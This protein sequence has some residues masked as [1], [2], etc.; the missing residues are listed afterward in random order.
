MRSVP[1]H[2][3]KAAGRVALVDDGD[4]EMVSKHRWTVLEVVRDGHLITGPYALTRIPAIG[5]DRTVYMHQMIGGP[6]LNDHANRY[7]LDNQRQNLRPATG[8]QNAANRPPRRTSATGFKGVSRA[9]TKG[10]WTARIGAN[11]DDRYLGTYSTP[12]DAARAYDAA[13][14]VAYGEFAYL[15]FPA[16]AVA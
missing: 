8:T 3:V 1:L 9:A 7:G 10:K 13:A 15:N 2:G 11:F 4:F 16:E 5:G 14:R 12:E 6:G